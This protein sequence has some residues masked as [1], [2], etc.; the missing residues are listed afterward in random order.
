MGIANDRYRNL[1]ATAEHCKIRRPSIV[2]IPEPGAG[3]DVQRGELDL[4]G[5]W[6]RLR[7]PHTGMVPNLPDSKALSRTFNRSRV[8]TGAA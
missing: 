1:I 7:K 8:V 5:S 4:L 3:S 2:G 6:L